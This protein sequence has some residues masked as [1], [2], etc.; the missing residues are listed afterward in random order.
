MKKLTLRK[1]PKSLVEKVRKWLSNDGCKFFVEVL[2]RS[3][4]LISVHFRE[5]MQ[6]RN[7]LRKQEECKGWDDHDFDNNWINIIEEA[8][9]NGKRKT[10]SG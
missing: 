2:L 4:N 7:F 6:V 1:Y 8:I 9:I 5:G 3:G 10:L